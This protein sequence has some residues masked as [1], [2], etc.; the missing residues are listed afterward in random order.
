MLTREVEKKISALIYIG[1]PFTSILVITNIVSDPVN[2]TK[3][4]STGIIACAIAALLIFKTNVKF[5]QQSRAVSLSFG[6]FLIAGLWAVINS[7]SPL[8]QNI[9]VTLIWSKVNRNAIELPS[10]CKCCAHSAGQ[11]AAT[12]NDPHL[13]LR[14]P[15]QDRGH[16]GGAHASQMYQAEGT[17]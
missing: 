16:E 3:L 5:W 14:T 1:A 13:P 12:D 15:L 9:Y 4:L 10:V 11:L 2:V 6:F 7:D 8:Q 17:S